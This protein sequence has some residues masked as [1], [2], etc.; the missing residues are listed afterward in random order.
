[1]LDF[2][3]DES[4]FVPEQAFVLWYL[5]FKDVCLDELIEQVSE[6]LLHLSSDL[7]VMSHLHHCTDSMELE[8]AITR[9]NFLLKFSLWQ[10]AHSDLP[11]KSGYFA[12]ALIF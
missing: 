7:M 11:L 12:R 4:H 1:M 9:P 10:L 5:L 2:R 6:V 3:V 8:L